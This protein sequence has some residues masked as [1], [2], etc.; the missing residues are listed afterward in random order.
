MVQIVLQLFPSSSSS[1]GPFFFFSCCNGFFIFCFISVELRVTEH[2]EMVQHRLRFCCLHHHEIFIHHWLG[3]PRS[4]RRRRRRRLRQGQGQGQP[5]T[6]QRGSETPLL[7]QLVVEPP[8]K[9][10]REQVREEQWGATQW[11]GAP[12]RT[13]TATSSLPLW[14]LSSTSLCGELRY[15]TPLLSLSLLLTHSSLSF[16]AGHCSV[17]FQGGRLVTVAK[18]CQGSFSS[19]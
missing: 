9:K 12:S 6:Q 1:S 17:W 13:R 14:R 4:P 8:S 19:K 18:I 5:G 10:R 11:G 2:I 16:C 15:S 7:L 3:P